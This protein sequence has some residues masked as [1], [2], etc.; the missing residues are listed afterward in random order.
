MP[1][2][3]FSAIRRDGPKP[4]PRRRNTA[5][6]RLTNGLYRSGSFLVRNSPGRRNALHCLYHVILPSKTTENDARDSDWLNARKAPV[7][8]SPMA[9]QRAPSPRILF[10]PTNP[11]R[12]P[13]SGHPKRGRRPSLRSS[14]S[15]ARSGTSWRQSWRRGRAILRL[16]GYE[17]RYIGISGTKAVGRSARRSSG[18]TRYAIAL[19]AGMTS[20]GL[21]MAPWGR[22]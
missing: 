22:M 21:V 14:A 8:F 3:T 10:D 18:G 12:C 17:V 9:S 11:I 15:F 4:Y 13:S 16:K 20:S 19:G 5:L 1:C 2:V 7:P 6:K